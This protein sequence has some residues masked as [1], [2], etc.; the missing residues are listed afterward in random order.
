MKYLE[1]SKIFIRPERVSAVIVS[2]DFNS[3]VD[4]YKIILD[5]KIVVVDLRDELVLT[6]LGLLS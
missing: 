1:Y 6:E 3:R 4:G 2:Y 5:G